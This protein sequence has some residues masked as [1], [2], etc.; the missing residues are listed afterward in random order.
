MIAVERRG[1]VRA[2]SASGVVRIAEPD[3]DVAHGY[4]LVRKQER[5]IAED[6][7]IVC[8]SVTLRVGVNVT[9]IP[10]KAKGPAGM[11]GD[12]DCEFV[13]R[14]EPEDFQMQLLNSSQVADRDASVS[15]GRQAVYAGRQGQV[16]AVVVTYGSERLGRCS[17]HCHRRQYC[18][19]N[20]FLH[21][22]SYYCSIQ[23]AGSVFLFHT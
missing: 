19:P 3:A 11:L 17:H 1:Y 7:G 10:G 16:E 23:I 15:G 18:T 14:C 13:I 21:Y 4:R 22:S 20:Y 9:L 2:P 12:E 6:A 5:F 8:D